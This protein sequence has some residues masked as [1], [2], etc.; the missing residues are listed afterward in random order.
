[1]IH[2]SITNNYY[3][4]SLSMK[5]QL[6]ANMLVKIFIY[7]KKVYDNAILRF[8]SSLENSFCTSSRFISLQNYLSMLRIARSVNFCSAIVQRRYVFI[9]LSAEIDLLQC[10][11]D[12]P[13][14]SAVCTRRVSVR[15]AS[16]KGTG[17]DNKY[18]IDL[19]SDFLQVSFWSN[20]LPF[21]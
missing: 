14:V 10:V 7:N 3:I 16:L 11:V 19:R 2:C 21:Q 6:L 12:T 5:L 20:L 1:M 8:R 4:Y 9:C 15:K 13:I 17:E 18:V